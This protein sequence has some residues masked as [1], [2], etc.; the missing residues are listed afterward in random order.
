[1]KSRQTAAWRRKL[2]RRTANRPFLPWLR[3]RDSLTAQIQSMGKFSLELVR[4]QLGR[5]TP[6]ETA[7]LA[8]RPRQLAWIREVSLQCN[9]QPV[10]F[11]HTV[12]TRN[13]RGPL[14][15]W[16]ARLGTRSLGALLFAHAGFRRGQ[17]ECRRLD[18]RHPLF[19]PAVTAMQ[20]TAAPPDS[21]WARRS[22]FV[23]GRQ[24][25]LVTEIF[26]PCWAGRPS[27]KPGF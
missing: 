19:M 10:V 15:M 6:D 2:P 5:P 12:L 18:H 11:A 22:H 13:P 26:S 7:P 9:G 24:K 16:L 1:M 23:F 17:L 20:L 4:Q 14:T 25:V 8:L 27:P 21:L 3:K